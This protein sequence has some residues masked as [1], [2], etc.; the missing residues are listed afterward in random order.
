MQYI[1]AA[2][3]AA[4][5]TGYIAD[6]S[7]TAHAA[8]QQDATNLGT[9]IAD[10]R[11][12]VQAWTHL[13]QPVVLGMVQAA[14]AEQRAAAGILNLP[15]LTPDMG[16]QARHR[17]ASARERLSAATLAS[18]SVGGPQATGTW[19]TAA[20]AAPGAQFDPELQVTDGRGTPTAILGLLA[21]AGGAA[22]LWRRERTRRR[23]GRR[24]R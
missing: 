23:G 1:P 22:W 20:P 24:Q 3:G 2:Y 17:L 13:M 10:F 14:S 15:V 7:V 8:L 11:V 6:P 18:Q 5:P 16:R 9:V 21:L 12:K 4:Y 19:Q